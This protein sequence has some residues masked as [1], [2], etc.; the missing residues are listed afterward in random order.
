MSR[1][2][3]LLAVV[4]V[5]LGSVVMLSRPPAAAQEATP[6]PAAMMAMAT[7]P[8]VGI[9]RFS[10]E[11]GDSSFPS[12]AIFHADG[13]YIEDYPDESSYSMGVWEPTG[14]RTV[15]LTLYQNYVIDD[16]LANLEGRLTAEVDE[17]GN[18]LTRDGTFVGLFEDGSIDIAVDGP[19][20]ATRLGILP[21]VPLAE[22]V[23]EGS[24][25]VPPE[26]TAATPAS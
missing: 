9:W 16:K 20:T 15:T 26:F 17:T 14:E 24:P 6:D 3:L 21:V 10:N 13:T 22:L 1:F 23:P 18:A 12:L 11:L 25:V 5:L 19:A 7:H 8:V 2:A 4:V